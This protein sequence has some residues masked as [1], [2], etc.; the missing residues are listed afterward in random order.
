MSFRQLLGWGS[1]TEGQLGLA[2]SDVL[3]P[4]PLAGLP[5]DPPLSFTPGLWSSVVVTNSAVLTTRPPNPNPLPPQPFPGS[6]SPPSSVIAAAV[7]REFA[8]LLTASGALYSFGSGAFGELGLHSRTVANTPTQIT[9]LAAVKVVDVTAAEFH[10]LCLDSSGTVFS[11]GN[12]AYGQLGLAHNDPVSVPKR[13]TALWPHP[14]VAVSTGDAHSAALSACGHIFCFG[15]NKQ[16]QLGTALFR[17]QVASLLPAVV[18]VPQPTEQPAT[19]DS[20]VMDI[21][22]YPAPFD[23]SHPQRDTSLSDNPLDYAM[24]TYVD[25]ACGSAHT[26]AL[27]SDGAIVCWGKGDSGQLGTRATRSLYQPTV[28]HAPS[29][30]VAVS[31]GDR[32]SAAVSSDG[33]AY[34]WGEGVHGQLGDGDGSDKFVPVALSPPRIPD[35]RSPVRYSRIM[36][37]GFHTL[38]LATDHD[39]PVYNAATVLGKRIPRCIVDN[40][41]QAKAGLSRFGSATVLLRTFVRPNVKH[42]SAHKV[43]Y[44][45]AETAHL[46][47]LHTFGD[48]GK[49]VLTLAAARIRHQAQIAFGLVRDSNLRVFG[50]DDNDDKTLITPKSHFSKDDESFRPTVANCPEV[51]YLF[52]LAMMNPIYSESENVPHLSELA[53]IVVRCEESAREAFLELVSQSEEAVLLNRLI[54]PLQGVLTDELRG[55]KRVTRNANFATKMLALCYHGVWRASRRRNLRGLSI[56]PKEFYNDTVSEM[57]NLME[58]YDRWVQS[59]MQRY[60]QGSDA[61]NNVNQENG[62]SPLQLTEL[63]PLP[64][65]GRKE[66]LFAFC[67]YSF[68]LTEAAKFKILE[69][70]SQTTMSEE[71]MRS[72]LSFGALQ[73]PFGRVSHIHLPADQAAHLQYLL[74]HVRRNHIVSDTYMRVADLAEKHPRALRK[75]LKVM[76][77]QEDGVDEGGLRKE[78]FQELMGHILS[79]DYGMFEHDEETQCHW[80]RKDFLEPEMSWTLIGIIF[81]LAAYNSILLDVQ[82][83]PVVYRKLALAVRC[84]Q[85][86]KQRRGEENAEVG[87]YKADLHDVKETFPSI[88][89]S[90]EQLRMYDG[91]DVEDVFCLTFEISYR[92][93]FD[94]VMN[95]ELKEDGA[96]IAVTRDNREEF[97]SLYID[98]LINSSIERAFKPFAAGFAFMVDGP[99]V[100]QL[101]A[102]ELETLVIGEKELDFSGLRQAAKYEGYSEKS[103][104]IIN[105]WQV[106]D[107]FDVALKRLFL[108]FVTGTDRAPIGGLHKLVLV[109]QRAEGDSNRLPTSHTCFNV[110]LLPE[111]RTR[112]KLRDRLLT[113]IRN[114][115]GFGLR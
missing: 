23:P 38:A 81:G 64:V 7:G 71:S 83:P 18:P 8:I 61:D 115:K 43:D 39:S 97:I 47:F 5:P 67:S 108:S 65:N 40:M 90:L 86:S 31:A 68:L 62:Y 51:G 16:G 52:F 48:E 111:Y 75:P 66:A 20:D 54:R 25:I 58:D 1:A 100:S 9:A 98:Y 36:C 89:N 82:F 45:A 21:D 87:R 76:F 55:Y 32:H 2:A 34:L 41:L 29:Q 72:F 91:D 4:R 44:I 15:S 12:N 10:W 22:T 79:P 112:A 28:T 33:V 49:K 84:A 59:A 94:K 3:T 85:L 95:V 35:A 70:E 102:D 42:F 50:D 26:V 56:S 27:R 73:M 107:E 99:F 13:V 105:F 104:V 92:G 19:A 46:K 77:D 17:V 78:F 96:N 103:V 37:G 109:I 14:I 114:S 74:L 80:L 60:E 6:P 110:L 63:P 24:A 30:F 106:L 88:G 93:L 11:C 53:A 113:A 57:V 69:Y 101:T